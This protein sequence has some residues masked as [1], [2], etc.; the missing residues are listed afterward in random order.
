VYHFTPTVCQQAVPKPAI[1]VRFNKGVF[2]QASTIVAG[3]VEYEGPRI[4]IPSSQQCFPE[5]CVQIHSLSIASFRQPTT[6]SFQPYPPNRFLIRL[7]DFDFFVTGQLSGS[8]F[9][10][11]QLP[12]FGTVYVSGLGVTVSAYMDIQKTSNDE[13]Y[14]R[15]LSCN[16]DSGIVEAKVANMG[17]LTD[18]VNFK[19]RDQ[20][21]AHSR[22]QLEMAICENIYRITQQHFSSRLYRLPRQIHANELFKM[23]L[24]A[25]RFKRFS[26][27]YYDDSDVA[28]RK[29]TERTPPS[30]STVIKNNAAMEKSSNGVIRKTHIS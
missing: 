17:L 21:S 15:M 12:V 8:I 11:I 22:A 19:Y 28:N 30:S 2:E 23:F 10:I 5:G 7:I 3:L 13:P 4:K 18:T 26:D 20:M 1:R 6:V 9:L 27:D 16:I 25:P 24:S 14:F 29:E